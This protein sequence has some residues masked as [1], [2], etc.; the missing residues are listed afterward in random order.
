MR[1][2]VAC[3][4]ACLACGRDQGVTDDQLKGLVA[5]AP[6]LAPIDV[7]QAAKDPAELSRALATTHGA[8]LVALGSHT[9]AIETH[10]IVD[11]GGKPVSD[12]SDKTVLELGDGAAFHGL[13]ENSADYGR[14]T[15]FIDGKLY[16]RPRYQKWHGRA[17]ET[18]DEPAQLRDAYFGAIAATWDLVA[19]GAE[20]TD[21][22]VT[23]QVA[24][25]AGRKI[26]FKLAPSPRENPHEA[27]SQR[28]WRESRT[29]SALDG[30]VTIDADKG[31]PLA[32]EMTGAIAFS[33]DGRRFTMKLS[34]K[35]GI[36][37]LGATA[38]A[39]PAETEVIAT[40]TRRGEV[41]ERDSLLHGIAPP[42][43]KNADGT[44][45][46]TP[47]PTPA[48]AGSGKPK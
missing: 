18:A 1:L 10:T 26:A 23:A 34:M 35:G 48:A 19:P 32:I 13:Y 4:L 9:L 11:E 43:R 28:Q 36:T 39:A 21:R 37:K 3:L 41:D 38:I 17:P 45:R 30:E 2:P 46:P 40:P 7:E 42:I 44:A 16:L 24:G 5:S 33:R 14:E 25:R 15:I 8:V 47:A 22:G 29:V 31:V 27:L 6:P 12:L 20:L